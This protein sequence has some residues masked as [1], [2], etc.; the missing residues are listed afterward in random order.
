MA[1]S[2]RVYC[3]ALGGTVE[4]PPHP[5]KV[6]SFVSGLTEAI[7]VIGFSERLAGVSIY[8]RRY[9]PELSAPVVGDY[10]TADENALLAIKPDLVVVTTGVQ[11]SLARRLRELGLPVFAFPLSATLYGILENVVL[12]GGLLGEVEA[13]RR[14]AETWYER[15]AKIR[16]NT[17]KCPLRVYPEVWLGPN[18]RIPGGLSFISDIIH[19][20]GGC[21]VYGTSASAYLK[22]DPD[23]VPQLQPEVWLLFSEPDHPVDAEELREQRGWHQSLPEMRLI[24]ASVAPDRNIIHDGPSMMKAV[25]WLSTSLSQCGDER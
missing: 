4:L 24:Q 11:R 5:Q 15:L 20:A 8:C 6:V 25:E 17:V 22:L 12:L 1:H 18:P 21:N 10:L 2:V 23:D 3:D 14:L 7:C 16:R 19:F 9:V 13:A